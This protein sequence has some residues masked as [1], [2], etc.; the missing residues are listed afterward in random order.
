MKRQLPES[1]AIPISQR[2]AS[3]L[4]CDAALL[5]TTFLRHMYANAPLENTQASPH[6]RSGIFESYFRRHQTT[7]PLKLP[8][9][10]RSSP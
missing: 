4:S 1:L 5:L 9:N 10:S 7:A 6:E 2:M 8:R 3:Y